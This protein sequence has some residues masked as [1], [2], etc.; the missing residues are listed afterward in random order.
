MTR[1]LG[2]HRDWPDVPDRHMVLLEAD[3]SSQLMLSMLEVGRKVALLTSVMPERGDVDAW[4]ASM[5]EAA[6]V[7]GGRGDDA[8][9][10]MIAWFTPAYC[11]WPE[12]RW[13]WT[14]CGLVVA[15]WEDDGLTGKRSH[16]AVGV[17]LAASTIARWLPVNVRTVR[18]WGDNRK[19]VRQRG[20]EL[21]RATRHYHRGDIAKLLVM[22]YAETFR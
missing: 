19:R 7:P 9:R 15:A 13:W 1:R 16:G 11:R 2:D 6:C 3:A 20:S 21:E 22:R 5:V 4:A 17:W 12:E 18:R 14:P 10:R 8:R